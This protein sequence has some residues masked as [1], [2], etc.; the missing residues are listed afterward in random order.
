[1]QIYASK[2][3]GRVTFTAGY[4]Y[5]K[6]LGDSS[7][8]NGTLENWQNLQYNYGSLSID[9]KHAFVGT[10]VWQIAE[11]RGQNMFVREVLGGWQLSG[12]GRAQSG[13]YYSITGSTT[14][15]NRRA[16]FRGGPYLVQSGRNANNYINKSAFIAPNA[17]VFGTSGVAP[18]EGPGLQQI[19]ATLAKTF[20]AERRVKAA[21]SGTCSTSST[22]PTTPISTQH[23]R[24]V[25][26]SLAGN[27][28]GTISAAYPPRQMQFG[29][30][31]IF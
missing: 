2:R 7:S 11:L 3:A 25:P 24:P 16:D 5:A 22:A 10:A 4:T 27:S 8:N 6:N 12:V 20:A 18:V 15:G 21:S 31:I 9:R 19:D 29:L 13:P 26:T 28:F 14:T 30:R 1:M 17:G 23:Y